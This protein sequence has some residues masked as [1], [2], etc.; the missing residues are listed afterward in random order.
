MVTTNFFFG[1]ECAEHTYYDLIIAE[2]DFKDLCFLDMKK[3]LR[4]V[5]NKT[6]LILLESEEDPRCEIHGEFSVSATRA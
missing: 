6:P 2:N 1:L 4:A 5:G 3:I